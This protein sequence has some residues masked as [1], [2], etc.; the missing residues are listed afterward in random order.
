VAWGTPRLTDDSK[1]LTAGG[2]FGEVSLFT[3]ILLFIFLYISFIIN[4]LVGGYFRLLCRG[5]RKMNN[6]KAKMPASRCIRNHLAPYPLCLKRVGTVSKACLNHV[7]TVRTKNQSLSGFPSKSFVFNDL[8][9]CCLVNPSNIF[10]DF[11]IFLLDIPA[12]LCYS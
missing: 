2:C 12:P 8:P 3:T 5:G 4:Y 9:S 11:L 6:E 1:V 10:L 7:Q